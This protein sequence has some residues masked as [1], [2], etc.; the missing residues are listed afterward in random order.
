MK[1]APRR[2]VK[3]HGRVSCISLYHSDL[4]HQAGKEDE[5]QS[6][7]CENSYHLTAGC[8]GLDGGMLLISAKSEN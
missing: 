5:P 3:P 4:P 2:R 8:G 7:E 6:Q 1:H